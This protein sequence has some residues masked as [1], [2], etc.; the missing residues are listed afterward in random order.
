MNL[1]G[2]EEVSLTSPMNF[3]L[4]FSVT[5]KTSESDKTNETGYFLTFPTFYVETGKSISDLS[6]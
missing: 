1:Q 6:S 3:H 5:L 4:N 2:R